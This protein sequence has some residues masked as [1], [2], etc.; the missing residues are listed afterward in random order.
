M[1]RFTQKL[2][3]LLCNRDSQKLRRRPI[4]RQ[5]TL[6]CLEERT[7]PTANASGTI[8]GVAF[9]DTNHNGVHDSGEYLLPGVSVNLSG[10]T[11]Q[12]GK[13]VNVTAVTNSQGAFTFDFVQPGT[14][15]IGFVRNGLLIGETAIYPALTGPA[16]VTVVAQVAVAGGKTVTQNVAYAGLSAAAVSLG[17]FTNS[18]SNPV[19]NILAAGSGV[20]DA[21]SRANSAPTVMTNAV[22]TVS[23][24]EGES[25]VKD[26]AGVFTDPDITNSE[27]QIN[28]NMGSIEV[29]LFDT[30]APQTVANFFDY[31][32]NGSYNNT[33][34]H[35]LVSDFVIQAGG[36]TLAGGNTPV[37]NA[38]NTLPDVPNEFG[39]SNTAGTL[40]MAKLGSDPN[41]ATSQ[42]FINLADNAS[43][44]DSQNGGFTVFGKIVGQTSTTAVSDSTVTKLAAS[45]ITDESQGDTSSAFT[46][47]PL[48]NGYVANDANFPTDTK[49]SD[50]D[51]IKSIQ[52]LS[53]NEALT[54]KVLSNSNPGL[55]TPSLE[56]E[57]LTLNYAQGKTGTATIKVEAIDEFG[58]TVTTTLTVNVTNQ[59]VVTGAIIA[60]DNTT[61]ATTLTATPTSTDPFGDTVTYTYQWLQNGTAIS[62]ATNASLSLTGLTINNSDTFSVQ[63]TPTNSAGNVGAVFTSTAITVATASPITFELPTITGVTIAPD[64]TTS[65]TTLTATP[66]STDPYSK[67]VTYTYQWLQN[68]TA[69]SDATSATLT[70][71]SATTTPAVGDNFSVEVTPSDGVTTGVLFTSQSV[72]LATA[73]PD[74]FDA[75]AATGVTIVPDS[76]TDTTTLTATDPTGTDSSYT[77]RTLTYTYQWD[78]NG[79]AIAST[80]TSATTATLDLTKLTVH[81]GD[82]FS[83][84]VTPSDGT[85]SGTTFTSS[86][87]T[88]ATIKPNTLNVPVVNSVA[89]APNSSTG[90]TTLTATPSS[91]DP[92]GRSVSYT[93]QWF[94]NGTAISGGTSQALDLTS[95]TISAGDSFTVQV[96]PSDG[97]VSGAAFTSKA[98]T[99]A[100]SSPITFEMPVVTSV[101]VTPNKA[102]GA[103]TLTAKATST[104]LNGRTVTYSYQWLENGTTISGAT[105]PTFKLSTVFLSSG[106]DFSVQVTPSDGTI[107]GTAFT[108][109]DIA[110][111]STSPVVIGL[112]VVDG[113]T[114]TPDNATS[115]TKLTATPT[116]NDPSSTSA[117]SYTYQW[118]LNGKAIAGATTRDPEPCHVGAQGSESRQHALRPGHPQRR[119]ACRKSL[120]E[121]GRHHCLRHSR[122]PRRPSRDLGG[123]RAGQPDQR[124]QVDGHANQH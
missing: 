21:S 64:S 81:K 12:Q 2:W 96:T 28:T 75:P 38:I 5:L 101:I 23:G 50:F 36:F 40:A 124:D 123:H 41:S 55:V 31:I 58:A 15:K 25:S 97:T 65:A 16:G 72:T 48:N 92:Y 115:I 39:A 106:E 33:I 30:T 95:L 14:Y 49:A 51:V 17:Q 32:L 4:G 89:I 20:A 34:F 108:S 9:V 78:Q 22:L 76:P 116:S 61:S 82:S 53:R 13:A 10:T 37:L 60:P 98:V 62:G 71:S 26:L 113:V 47:V 88:L 66:A 91:H 8:T 29:Q 3:N 109:G 87:V 120:H 74:T 52:V 105:S 35:R 99:V 102:S 86:A 100:T 107:S 70:L 42:F 73:S 63:I 59:P 119:H 121:P 112:P 90:A 77:G 85:I 111:L 44:L 27:V 19:A 103:T 84:V 24:A 43:N 80:V 104:D 56:D 122:H 110:I 94:Q 45:T 46:S 93:Y 67:T 57:Y 83:V 118:L 1:R 79:K 114:I 69:I 6:E 54:Y 11:S 68:G 117:I 7:T 18:G